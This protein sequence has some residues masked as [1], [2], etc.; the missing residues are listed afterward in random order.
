MAG[1]INSI[2]DTIMSAAVTISGDTTKNQAPYYSYGFK[3]FSTNE[4][5]LPQVRWRKGSFNVRK[6]EQK[7]G[8]HTS[9]I[10]YA[11]GSIAT[12]EQNVEC[13][14]WGETEQQVLNEFGL[15]CQA[16]R[17]IK[18]TNPEN[19]SQPGLQE[20]IDGEWIETSAHTT[21]GEMLSFNYLVKINIAERTG[22]YT[23]IYSA[24]NQ[25][26]GSL[27]I[28]VEGWTIPT[29]SYGTQS[30]SIEYIVTT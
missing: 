24:S 7:S 20:I 17:F 14:I 10:F 15:I 9:E 13:T 3:S 25:I 30:G 28:E 6:S 27:A 4:Q 5:Q 26:T 21:Q 2:I 19:I 18:G 8:L 22:E 23:T 12:I 1:Q 29:G 11:S 16:I